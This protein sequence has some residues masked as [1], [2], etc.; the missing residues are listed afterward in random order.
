M[1]EV[2]FRCLQKHISGD[3][4]HFEVVD[5][6]PG[7]AFVCNTECAI[8]FNRPCAVMAPHFCPSDEKAYFEVTILREPADRYNIFLG[9]GEV[10]ADNIITMI[11]A[12]VPLKAGS[13][14]GLC[15][16]L[17]RNSILALLDG[18][19]WYEAKLPR[20]EI[21]PCDLCPMINMALKPS[22]FTKKHEKEDYT[23]EWFDLRYNLGDRAF[24]YPR[25]GFVGFSTLPKV[26]WIQFRRFSANDMFLSS[27][28]TKRA[29]LL[30][31]LPA[32]LKTKTK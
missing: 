31:V 19:Q 20:N 21:Q 9:F 25:P 2:L 26:C 8:R 5:Q 17:Q 11:S 15:C 16:D 13:V 7:R 23:Y 3:V 6:V 32:F 12:D 4:A 29:A 24:Q 1:F 27:G 10:D 22:N 14:I 18:I 30:K 28:D